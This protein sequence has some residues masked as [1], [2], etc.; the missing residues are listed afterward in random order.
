MRAFLEAFKL[1]QIDKRSDDG[2]Y[3]LAGNFIENGKGPHD[4][5]EWFIAEELALFMGGA[6]FTL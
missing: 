1:Y 2:T 3:R 6:G 4:T 5:V